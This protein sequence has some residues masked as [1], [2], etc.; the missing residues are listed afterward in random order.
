MGYEAS[1][2]VGMA[3]SFFTPVQT[4]IFSPLGTNKRVKSDESNFTSGGGNSG[5]L[6]TS[7]RSSSAASSPSAFE[8]VSASSTSESCSL[9]ISSSSYST[10]LCFAR[11]F[12]VAG[13]LRLVDMPTGSFSISNLAATSEISYR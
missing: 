2:G 8:P 12:F 11:F 1:S 6:E 5:M 3:T 13:I 7:V 4:S 9:E 10:F